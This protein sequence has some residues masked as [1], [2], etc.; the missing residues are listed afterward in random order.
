MRFGNRFWPIA[1]AILLGLVC[2]GLALLNA[3]GFA[4]AAAWAFAALNEGP[5]SL[6]G[7][8][9]GLDLEV[10]YGV[11]WAGSLLL[12]IAIT[13][14]ILALTVYLNRRNT[15]MRVIGRSTLAMGLLALA[16]ILSATIAFAWYF[17]IALSYL[18]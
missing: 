15:R 13:G 17:I 6:D 1:G 12:G 11:I 9:R 7:P 3:A 18:H 16:S 5:A 10:S 8:S 4:A 14:A 2:A